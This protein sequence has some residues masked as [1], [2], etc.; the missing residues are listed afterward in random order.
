VLKTAPAVRTDSDREALWRGLADGAI[1]FVT[2]DHAPCNLA[3]GKQHD[4]IWQNY[5]GIPGVETM[6]SYLYEAGVIQRDLSLEWLQR[7][8]STAAR[9]TFDLPPGELLPGAPATFTLINMDRP[10]L[11]DPKQFASLGKYSPFAGHTF[12]ASIAMTVLNGKVLFDG[13]ELI[14]Q[15][16]GSFM[17]RGGA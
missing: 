14:G 1:D 3:T 5:S 4:D 10:W 16:T 17:K 6:V 13:Q 12:P 11:V 2:T 9:K 7:V 15:A 8:T